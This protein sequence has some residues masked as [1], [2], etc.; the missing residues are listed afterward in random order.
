MLKQSS[1]WKLSHRAPIKPDHLVV[2]RA[3]KQAHRLP[4]HL[5]QADSHMDFDKVSQT[6]NKI[7]AFP[8]S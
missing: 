6:S 5:G 4:F 2:R 7:W 1:D 3:A 8:E